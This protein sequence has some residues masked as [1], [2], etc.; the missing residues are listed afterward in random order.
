MSDSTY[1]HQSFGKN[2]G[3]GGP[4]V[5]I[6]V[7]WGGEL[8]ERFELSPPRSFFLGDAS[9]SKEHIDFTIPEAAAALGANV[10]ALVRSENG[11]RKSVV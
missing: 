8:L 7:F 4:A 2:S 6:R 11:D 3:S 10:G 5:E 1:I 9:E